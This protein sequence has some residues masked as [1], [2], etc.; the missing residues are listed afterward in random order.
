MERNA[1]LLI[2]AEYHLI[3]D[4]NINHYANWEVETPDV[5]YKAELD[6]GESPEEIDL[7]CN[8]RLEKCQEIE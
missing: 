5:I 2:G 6:E 3:N 7:R 1:G 8:E 4:S